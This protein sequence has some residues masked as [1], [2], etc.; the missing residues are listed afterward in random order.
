MD[1]IVVGSDGSDHATA[2]L[3]WAV[4]EAEVHGAEVEVVLVW[5]LLDQYHADH[6][7]DFDPNYSDVT[8][9][10]ALA[11]WIDETIDA[12][13]EVTVRQR[14]VCD[15]PARAL[16]EAGDAADLLA[17]GAR[18]IGGFEGLL[19]GSVSERVAQLANRP[20]AVIRAPAP[21]PHGDVAVGIDGSAR[22]LDA[23]RWAAA[24]ARARDAELHVLHA[25]RLPLM[26]G[27]AVYSAAFDLSAMEEGG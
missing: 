23:L 10:A 26:T 4:E 25:W 16:L 9:G 5:S 14:V 3:L 11:S 20:V 15:L 24:E 21:V 19:L 27:P 17:L 8:A 22:S 13:S 2:A 7:K 6:T 18:G 1:K 12:T